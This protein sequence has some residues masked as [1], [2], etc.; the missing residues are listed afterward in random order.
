M[1]ENSF[2]LTNRHLQ[3]LNPI[4]AGTHDC[5][6]GYGIQP[7]IRNYTLIHYVF[8]GKG[9]LYS[10]SG[11]HPVE[12]GQAFLIHQGERAN[13][14]ADEQDPW[15]YC[16]IGFDGSLSARFHSLPAVLTPSEGIFRGIIRAAETPSIA[17]YLMAADLFRLYGELFQSHPLQSPH[18]QQVK[19]YIRHSYMHPLRIAQIAHQLNLDRRYLSRLFK[20][21]T[22]T[23]I[24]Q[25]LLAVRMDAA[26]QYLSRGLSVKESARMSGYEDISN[27]TKLYKKHFGRSPAD[28]RKTIAQIVK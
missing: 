14:R 18:V 6:P 19:N 10:E 17:E 27:F 20:A 3:D 11:T 21:Q 9:T 24:Q 5:D 28:H 25:Y 4:I 26:D 2:L 15:F 16:W 8:R 7:A 13:Y 12:A 22:G 1:Q 23:S